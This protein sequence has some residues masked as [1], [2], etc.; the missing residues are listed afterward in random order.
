[1][2][3][4]DIPGWGTLTLHHIVLDYNGTMAVDGELIPGVSDRLGQMAESI[5]IHVL[6]ADTF[7]VV[8]QAVS[9]IP[10][11]LTVL[12]TQSQDLGKLEYVAG[13]GA[14]Q[15]VCIGNGRN[16]QLMLKEAALGI[17]VMQRE[18]LYAG[19]LVAADLVV[20]DIC[21]ALDLLTH[22]M[23]LVAGLRS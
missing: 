13:L 23:R 16:D 18:G 8:R 15:C 9:G 11:H 1:V 14:N 20:P 19:S 12:G 3:Q 21:T 10:C 5:E 2:I 22:P 7:G 6:T 17:A 4:V